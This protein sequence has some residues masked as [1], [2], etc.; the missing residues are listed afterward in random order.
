MSLQR[1]H[2]LH[3]PGE[4][5]RDLYFPLDCLISLTVTMR[6]GRT[7]ETGLVGRLGVVG[8]NAFMGGRETTQTEYVIQTD[9]EAVWVPAAPLRKEFNRNQ[10]LRDVL[11]RYTQAVIAQA[12]QNAA[13]NG[14][15]KLEQRFARWLLEVRD[16]IGSDDLWLTHELISD[17]LGVRRAGIG[18]LS[19][20][21][22]ERGLIVQG[23]GRTQ[24][25]DAQELEAA[26]CECYG[27]MREEYDRLLGRGRLRRVQPAPRRRA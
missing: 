18:A 2:V 26:A 21:F 4:P 20:K 15:H 3:R 11:L 6:D 5:I 10:V 9:G 27:V 1:G 12:S 8:I 7:A 17:M 23:R 14:L 16:R 25:I 22:E 13:C 24:I 19:G